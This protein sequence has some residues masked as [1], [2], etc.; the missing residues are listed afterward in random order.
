MWLGQRSG[1]ARPDPTLGVK[2]APPL[3]R[4][5]LARGGCAR[6]GSSVRSRPSGPLAQRRDQLGRDQSSKKRDHESPN[7]RDD[8]AQARHS[9]LRPVALWTPRYT[10]LDT[11]YGLSGYSAKFTIAFRLAADSTSCAVWMA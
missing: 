6:L 5:A 10:R 8:R 1:L 4:D 3:A 11:P 2:A 7:K 9:T